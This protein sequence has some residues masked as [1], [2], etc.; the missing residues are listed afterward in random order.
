MS[1]PL[2]SHHCE[3]LQEAGRLVARVNCLRAVTVL[4]IQVF[5]E[6]EK[7]KGTVLQNV[8]VAGASC[9]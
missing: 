8:G 7:G 5:F 1:S 2:T 4:H 6:K 3:A 9:I